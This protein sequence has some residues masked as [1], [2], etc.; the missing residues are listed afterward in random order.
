MRFPGR[1]YCH[2]CKDILAGNMPAKKQ[3]KRVKKQ[4]NSS[5]RRWR[6][7]GRNSVPAGVFGPSLKETDD[8][9][10]RRRATP[11]PR[12]GNHLQVGTCFVRLRQKV[13]EP[14]EKQH[15][16]GAKLYM[17]QRMRS[18]VPTGCTSF[19]YILEPIQECRAFTHVSSATKEIKHLF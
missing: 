17:Q 6:S 3:K 12:Q 11:L 16:L 18:L 15:Q 13:E 8:R 7:N 19:V 4:N 2:I 5:F 1:S 14:K 10:P 9:V